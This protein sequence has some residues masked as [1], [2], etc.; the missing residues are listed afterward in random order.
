MQEMRVQFKRFAISKYFLFGFL[1]NLNTHQV[2]PATSVATSLT[3]LFL[4]TNSAITLSMLPQC[5]SW[6]RR[7]LLSIY[8][9]ESYESE[10]YRPPR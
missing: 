5:F 3:R 6:N 7:S 9:G 8:V 10:C 2:V 1:H 4:K